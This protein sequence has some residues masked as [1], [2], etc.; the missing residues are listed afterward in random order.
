[1]K[2]DMRLHPRVSVDLPAELEPF[3]GDCVDV[4]LIYLSLSGALVEG[5]GELEA[6]LGARRERVAGI[7]LELNLHFGLEAASV[8]CHCRVVHSRRLAQDC[9]Q[10]G[11]KILSLPSQSQDALNR[12]IEA[13]LG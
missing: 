8:H 9:F 7:P 10:V 5:Q 11:L 1:M 6:L 3:H 4:R 2:T 13:R 12:Y